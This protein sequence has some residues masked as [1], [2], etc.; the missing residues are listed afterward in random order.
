MIENVRAFFNSGG[1]T[2]EIVLATPVVR[3]GEEIRGCVRVQGGAY[4]ALR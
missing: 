2:A 4:A 1:P 3:P